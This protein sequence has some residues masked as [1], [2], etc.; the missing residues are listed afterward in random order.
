MV[1]DGGAWGYSRAGVVL[2]LVVVG[3]GVGRKQEGKGVIF[4]V[5][6]VGRVGVL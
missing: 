3:V 6:G 2:V 5:Y 1:V 4:L